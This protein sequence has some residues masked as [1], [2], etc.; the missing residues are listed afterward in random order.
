[1]ADAAGDAKYEFEALFKAMVR[2]EQTGFEQAREAIT[3]RVGKML[4][5]VE[6]RDFYPPYAEG[7]RHAYQS[8]LRFI[9]L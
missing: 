3:R 5:D 2:D 8:V 9:A 1:M 6:E 7:M 4:A